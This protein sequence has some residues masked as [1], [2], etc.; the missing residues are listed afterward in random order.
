MKPYNDHTL[1]ELRRIAEY[2]STEYNNI[3]H[4]VNE[5]RLEYITKAVAEACTPKWISVEERLPDN[6]QKIYA[7]DEDGNQY[8]CKFLDEDMF[9]G[10]PSFTHWIPQLPLPEPPK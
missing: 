7:L 1:K 10:R 4:K 9:C 3:D 5:D 8:P 6:E 2:A